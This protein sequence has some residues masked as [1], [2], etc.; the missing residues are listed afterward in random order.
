MDKNDEDKGEECQTLEAVPDLERLI[1]VTQEL[2]ALFDDLEDSEQSSQ[3]DNLGDSC[4]S[5]DP[6]KTVQLIAFVLPLAE[7]AFKRND[8][9][10][11]DSEPALEVLDCD[12]PA[13]RLYN[14]FFVVKGRIEHD[15]HV[16]EEE[17]V[18]CVRDNDPREQ[19]WRRPKA[20]AIGSD[21]A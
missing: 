8:G 18:D 4:D 12:E 16:N 21:E 14:I 3:L 19:L 5:G 15:D 9:K 13:I 17:D 2:V 6:R 7:D 20:D 10:S 1:H 11:I